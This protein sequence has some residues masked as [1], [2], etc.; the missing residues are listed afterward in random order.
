MSYLCNYAFLGDGGIKKFPF[1]I[2][3]KKCNQK[4]SGGR[5]AV[6]NNF[7]GGVKLVLGDG[8]TEKKLGC[9]IK[10]NTT[11]YSAN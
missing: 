7:T 11:L 1:M 5:G 2:T 4:K 10:K 3:L 6:N 9:Q 8:H